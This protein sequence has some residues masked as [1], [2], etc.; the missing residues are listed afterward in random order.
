MT[1]GPPVRTICSLRITFLFLPFLLLTFPGPLQAADP[2]RIQGRLPR[3]VSQGGV[4][5]VTVRPA[6]WIESVRGSLDAQPLIFSPL[7]GG[8]VQA[9]VGIDLEANGQRLLR[10]EATDRQGRLHVRKWPI[11][12]RPRRFLVQRLTL[13]RNMVELDPETVTRVSEEADRLNHLWKTVTPQRFWHGAFQSPVPMVA[14]PEGFGL[15]RI[16]NDQPRSPHSGADYKA[17]PGSVV[18]ASNAARVALAEEQFFGGNALVLDH[19]LGL[20]TIYFHLQEFLVK[21]GDTVEKGQEIGKVGATGRA[22]GPHLHFGVRLQG[23]RI[24]P[25]ALLRLSLR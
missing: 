17:P 12:V 14:A 20:Y 6:A 7:K 9:L 21:M 8:R 15:R 24:D 3:A 10:L 2:F 18:R 13:P 23:A 22:T 19:G 5:T 4:F 1:V 11:R 25:T 16:I